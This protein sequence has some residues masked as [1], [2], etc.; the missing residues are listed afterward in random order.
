MAQA[1]WGD[2]AV[3][4]PWVL[5][6]RFGDL[7]ILETQ[8]ASMCAWVD[9]VAQMAGTS[10]LWD[11]GFQYGDWLD[12]SAPPDQ[13]EQAR[14]GGDLVATAYFAHS[15]ELVSHIA[16]LL[17]KQAEEQK[18]TELAAEVRAAF[19]AQFLTPAGRTS[20]DAETAYALVLQFGLLKEPA[21]RQV[22][23]RRLA[24]LV[25]KVGYHISTGFLG[26]P[27]ICDALC[28]RRVRDH[29]LSLADPT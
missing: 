11:K 26:T 14:A 5:Y 13:A 21:Q 29:R 25:R 8:F 1:G 20:Y 2:A 6:Q 9:F 18:Y 12:P 15:A 19:T 23:G 22:A 3:I 17:G 24:E 7:G 28:E 10:R 4:V 16:S 27:L